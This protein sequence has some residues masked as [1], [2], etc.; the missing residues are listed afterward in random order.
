M[1]DTIIAKQLRTEVTEDGSLRLSLAEQELSPPTGDGIVV[2]IAATPINPSDLGLLLGPVDPA[3]ARQEGD[4]LVFPIPP[5]RMGA[6]AARTGQSMPVGNEGAGVVVQAGPEA[7]ALLGKTVA[8]AGGS[9]YA[10]HRAARAREAMVLPDGVSAEQGASATVNPMTALG[11]VEVMRAEGHKA[12]V[13]T[14]AA[15]NLGQMLNRICLADGVPLVN[16][17]RSAEQ[18]RLLKDQGAAHVLDSTAEGFGRALVEALAATGATLAF[19]AVGGGPLAGRI[20]GAMEQAASA[21]QAFSRYGSTAHKQ[22][23]IYGRLDL[24]PT[25]LAANA[26]FAW[27]VSGFL[28]TPFLAADPAR[29]Q[30]MR[31]R[32]MA[33][34]TTTFAS[35][36][37]ETIGLTDALRPEVLQ[38]YARRATGEKF[39]IDPRR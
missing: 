18:V 4:A 7:Q 6:L 13:H 21:G 24:R 19:D 26:G 17:V 9:M 5:Q 33:E 27:S 16:I 11:M 39:L 14:A 32:V 1:A 2:E 31:E 34:L 28:L 12:L 25:E 38:R 30:R 23:Y 3:D 20:L 8:L 22:V 35:G 15:S 10:T 29:A 37:T 36:Y